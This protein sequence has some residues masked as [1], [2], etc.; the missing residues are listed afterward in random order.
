MSK[1]RRTFDDREFAES[2]IRQ[3]EQRGSLSERQQG[4]L[5]KLLARYSGQ[6]PDYASQ[7]EALGLTRPPSPPVTVKASCPECGALLVARTN[8]RRGTTFY[9]CSAFPKCRYL[10]NELP[11]AT[12]DST[13]AATSPGP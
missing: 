8:R 5:K 3:F 2:L 1:G 10:C 11:A 12:T 7:A 6:I 13:P 4:A 9:G